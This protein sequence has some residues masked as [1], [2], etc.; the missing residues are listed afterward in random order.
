MFNLQKLTAHVQ[1][2]ARTVADFA[3]TQVTTRQWFHHACASLTALE[4]HAINAV[5]PTIQ[6]HSATKDTH[7]EGACIARHADV[8]DELQE[9]QT[10]CATLD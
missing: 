2:G 7:F 6:Q 8:Y 3:E 5:L 9:W 1:A 4:Y 10:I